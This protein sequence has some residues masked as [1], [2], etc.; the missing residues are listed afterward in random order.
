MMTTSRTAMTIESDT[1]RPKPTKSL[2]DTGLVVAPART[3]LIMLSIWSKTPMPA[4]IVHSTAT[5]TT[6]AMPRATDSRNDIF[7]AD[8]GSIR[9]TVS[10]TRRPRLTVTW[11]GRAAPAVPE[12]PVAATPDVGTGRVV[13]ADGLVDP[14]DAARA[15][16]PVSPVVL[17]R[18]LPR[19]G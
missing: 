16:I 11:A 4:R 13:A 17:T 19:R 7:I 14:A 15:V 18:Y 3:W 5:M 2:I 10:L 1:T 8:Q 6:I 9:L 12:A